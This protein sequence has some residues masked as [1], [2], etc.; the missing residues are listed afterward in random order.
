VLQPL[1]A[2]P[3][4]TITYSRLVDEVNEICKLTPPLR[5]YQD[6]RLYDA[7]GDVANA[8][9]ARELPPLTALVVLEDVMTPSPA[10]YKMEYPQLRDEFEK[11]GAWI[12]DLKRVRVVEFPSTL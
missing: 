3:Q 11:L 6:K 8:C 1:V 4:A 5:A 7:L 10:Y 9:K 2:D 12:E